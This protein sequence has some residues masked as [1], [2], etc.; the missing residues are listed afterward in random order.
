MRKMTALFLLFAAVLWA[1]GGSAFAQCNGRIG[2][3]PTNNIGAVMYGNTRL[4]N[5]AGYGYPGYFGMYANGQFWKVAAI[6]G[7][8]GILESLITTRAQTRQLEILANLARQ[9]PQVVVQQQVPQQQ[10][11]HTFNLNY[12]SPQPQP[13]VYQQQSAA[14]NAV[15]GMLATWGSQ[16]QGQQ[17]QREPV[18]PL[19]NKSGFRVR[20]TFVDGSVTYL[21]RDRTLKLTQGGI[22]RIAGIDCLV[23]QSSGVVEFAT[24]FTPSEDFNSFYIIAPDMGEKGK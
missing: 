12:G 11:Q 5:G 9:Q 18:Y 8:T 2:G 7:V 23:A 13:A 10:E 14:P 20:L 6:N 3:C 4:L 19:T 16:D 22:D 17:V 1:V 21:E 15:A 24:K